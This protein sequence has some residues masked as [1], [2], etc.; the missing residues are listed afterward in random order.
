VYLNHVTHCREWSVYTP[1]DSKPAAAG[2]VPVRMGALSYLHKTE[3]WLEEGRAAAAVAVAA[4]VC[5]AKDA[6][7]TAAAATTWAG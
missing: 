7:A 2:G 3:G 6:A 1:W 4:A 5:N